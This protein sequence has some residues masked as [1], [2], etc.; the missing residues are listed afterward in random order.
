VALIPVNINIPPQGG[1]LSITPSTGTAV[2]DVFNISVV[3]V[4]DDDQP[5]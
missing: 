1:V 4:E 2:D 5:L 3:A